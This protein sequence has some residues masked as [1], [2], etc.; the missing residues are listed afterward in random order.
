MQEYSFTINHE[1]NDLKCFFTTAISEISC[2]VD[3][4]VR[5]QGEEPGSIDFAT[6]GDSDL[7]AYYASPGLNPG[8]QE[9]VG[10]ALNK[11]LGKSI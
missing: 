10:K 2:R 5:I 8:I 1:G 3:Y 7:F 11:A 4:F 9:A 6:E